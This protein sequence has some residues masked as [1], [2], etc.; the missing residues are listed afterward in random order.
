MASMS[1]LWAMG[2]EKLDKIV[3]NNQPEMS[4]TLE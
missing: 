2:G 1:I 4:A 3:V